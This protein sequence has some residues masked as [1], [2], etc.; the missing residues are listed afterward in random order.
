MYRSIRK[1]FENIIQIIYRFWYDRYI[2][3]RLELLFFFCVYNKVA[4]F[5]A[6]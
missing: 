1:R 5:G 6:R 3:Y 2:L 4:N